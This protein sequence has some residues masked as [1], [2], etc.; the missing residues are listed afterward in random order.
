MGQPC[1]DSKDVASGTG[2]QRQGS[3]DR[4]ER[5]SQD[6]TAIPGQKRRECRGQDPW[7]DNW[8]RTAGTGQPGRDSQDRT[9]IDSTAGTAQ[10]EKTVGIVHLD[11]KQGTGLQEQDS[12]DRPARTG[13]GDGTAMEGQLA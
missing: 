5:T 7:Q 8:H 12:K 10:P 3:R 4:T 9:S 11:R 6:M 1:H 2:V 13:Q